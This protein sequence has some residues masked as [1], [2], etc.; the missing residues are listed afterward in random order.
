[1]GTK[2]DINRIPV[3]HR[4][5]VETAVKILEDAGCREVYL[6]GSMVDGPVTPRSDIDVAAKGI[7]DGDF[8]KIYARLMMQL[9]HPVD[10]VSIEDDNRF[11]VMLQ[12]EG[13]L[14]RVL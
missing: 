3:S 2:Y 1:M 12:K 4:H 8:F 10:L 14:H 11:S 5:D 7:P 9:E 6:F 13:Y